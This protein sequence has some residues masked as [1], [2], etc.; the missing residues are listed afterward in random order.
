MWNKLT[1]WGYNLKNHHVEA[2]NHDPVMTLL[3]PEK[4]FK[5]ILAVAL[6]I[7]AVALRLIWLSAPSYSGKQLQNSDM[8]S[9]SGVPYM[10]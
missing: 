3:H 6:N 9:F 5:L 4:D 7:L 2:S 10:L 1:G 8:C